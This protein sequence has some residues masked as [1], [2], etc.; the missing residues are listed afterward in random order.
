MIIIDRFEG[1]IAVVEDDNGK[2]KEVK[3]SMLPDDADEGDVL[4]YADGK[5]TVDHEATE[6]R[7]RAVRRKLYRLVKRND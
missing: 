7:R 6:E 3:R 5:Y 2:C 1:N 4:T